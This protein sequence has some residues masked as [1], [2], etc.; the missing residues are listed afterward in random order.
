MTDPYHRGE[1]AVQELVG[2][3]AQAEVNGRVIAERIEWPKAK[4]FVGRQAYCVWGRR[5]S[6][7]E[8]WAAFVTG[9]EGFAQVNDSGSRIEFAVESLESV[10]SFSDLAAG[11]PLGMLFIDLATR[12]RLRVNGEI[13]GFED[14][15]LAVGIEQAYANCPKYIQRRASE[16]SGASSAESEII[17]GEAMIGEMVDWISGADTFFVAGAHPEGAVDVSHRGGRPGFVQVEGGGTA[18]SRLS[19]Q[20]DVQHARQLLSQPTSRT[21]VRRF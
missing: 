21:D 6:S 16:P 9:D 14:G 18:G 20:L 4:E 15:R 13:A 12:R 5:V 1:V 10:P 7:G 8:P 19:G 3:R 17:E 11:D 2:E